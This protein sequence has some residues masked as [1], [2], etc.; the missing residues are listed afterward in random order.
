MAPV[1]FLSEEADPIPHEAEIR[2][3][4]FLANQEQRETEATEIPPEAT[5]L[6]N[7]NRYY[8]CVYP[9]YATARVYYRDH[10]EGKMARGVKKAYLSLKTLHGAKALRSQFSVSLNKYSMAEAVRRLHIW[11]L[12]RSAWV[13]DEK[14]SAA[15][16]EPNLPL[17]RHMWR[18]RSDIWSVSRGD[19]SAVIPARENVRPVLISI[20]LY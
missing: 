19:P 5:F 13:C 17:P 15:R 12:R 2:G 20:A 3:L 16:N 14:P 6:I 9:R 7:F 8:T 1:P 10:E 11:A 18:V 4:E